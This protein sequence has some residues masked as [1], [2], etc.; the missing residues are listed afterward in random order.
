[1]SQLINNLYLEGVLNGAVNTMAVDFVLI[2]FMEKTQF[3]YVNLLFSF[4]EGGFLNENKSIRVCK[5]CNFSEFCVPQMR[6][7]ILANCY[8]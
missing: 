7:A 8:I 4:N 2:N 3:I 5:N 6:S 1:M